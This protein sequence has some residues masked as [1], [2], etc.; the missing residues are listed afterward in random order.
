METEVKGGMDKA[1]K[2]V[3]KVLETLRYWNMSGVF[4]GS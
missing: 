4:C 1:D 2:K 3:W